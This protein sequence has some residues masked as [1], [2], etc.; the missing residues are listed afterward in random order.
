MPAIRVFSTGRV[1]EKR[2]LRGVRRY[3]AD[4]WRDETLPVN[5]FL[6]EHPAG[7]CL[8]DAGQTAEAAGP[9]YFDRW[10]PFFRLSRFELT[11]ADEAATQLQ[12]AGHAVAD[13]RWVV[14]THLHTDHVGGLAPFA[15]ASVV[16]P[17][18][19]WDR[20]Q[21]L[22]GRL[23]GYL[24]QRW[25]AHLAPKVVDFTGPPIG[26][27]PASHDIAG[28]GALQLVPLPGHTPG[29]AALLVRFGAGQ[30]GWLCVGDAVHRASEMAERH[31][32]VAEWC[33]REG[34]AV[35]ASHDDSAG[36]LTGSAR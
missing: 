30:R 6:V 18:M 23:R 1:R 27:F 5:V 34:V 10:Y 8:V 28:D 22:G 25:P 12:A 2:G 9:G 32:A 4:D 11:T 29:H 35:L 33:A 14:C 17:R 31:P 24:P 15:Q 36:A 20:A 26:P 16:V 19:E 7:L 13:V 3:F 21:G